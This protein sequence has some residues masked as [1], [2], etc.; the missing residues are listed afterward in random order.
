MRRNLPYYLIV[1]A[2][3]LNASCK[4]ISS[5]RP[6]LTKNIIV[7]LMD[8][9]RYSETWGDS[10]HKYIPHL[11]GDLAGEGVVFTNFFN[12]GPTYTLSGHTAI[13]TG[14]HQEID[15]S[16]NELPD[17]PSFFQIYRKSFLKDSTMT[18]I[19]TSKDKLEVLR[20]CKQSGWNGRYRPLTDCGVSGNGSGYRLDSLTCEKVISVLRQYHPPMVL[21]NFRD[22]D[23]SGHT[24]V[25]SEYVKGIKMVD[26]Y[27]YNIWRFLQNDEY[28][29]NK[30]A[31]FVTND[32][33][34]HLDGIS[35]GFAGHGDTCLGCRHIML[36]ASGPDFNKGKIVNYHG[37]LIDLTK[38]ISYLLKFEMPDAPGRILEELFK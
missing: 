6:I 7:I 13:T 3:L 20:D 19:I 23:F 32:H 22:P 18:W 29:K 36:Y 24:G 30:T 4:R 27:L 38:T 2:L 21:V 12:N 10:T 9:A 26:G 17:K 15:N 34:R 33:G 28:Y 25:Y 5:D 14:I 35:D 31:F 8:G 11:A 16:G 37:D 1:L